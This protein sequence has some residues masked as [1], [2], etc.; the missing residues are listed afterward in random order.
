MGSS[1]SWNKE[2]QADGAWRLSLTDIFPAPIKMPHAIGI[3][4]FHR[5]GIWNVQTL[6]EL[7]RSFAKDEEVV[8]IPLIAQP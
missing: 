5:F 8:V 2:V 6:D 1:G 7:Y 4:F 3:G